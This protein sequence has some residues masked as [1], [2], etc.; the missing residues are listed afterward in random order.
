[1]VVG[2]AQNLFV[3]T[4][5]LL[6]VTAEEVDLDAFHAQT[7]HPAHLFFADDGII[8]FIDGALLDVVPIATGTVPQ[9]YVHTFTVCILHQFLHAFISR[10]LVPP[11]IYQNIFVA[12]SRSQIDITYLVIIIGTVVL[13]KNPTPSAAPPAYTHVPTHNAVPPRPRER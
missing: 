12:H 4:Q 6:L 9:E 1:M 11:A 8:H 10:H 13:P 5:G 2:I 3:Q 7:L